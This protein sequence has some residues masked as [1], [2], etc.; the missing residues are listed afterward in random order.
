M[1]FSYIH[2]ILSF[3]LMVHVIKKI[4]FFIFFRPVGNVQ[5]CHL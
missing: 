1:Y 2:D 3:Y 5:K 4:Y